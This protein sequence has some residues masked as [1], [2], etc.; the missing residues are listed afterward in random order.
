[1]NK[2]VNIFIIFAVLASVICS[3]YGVAYAELSGKWVYVSNYTNPDGSTGTGVS[4]V[5]VFQNGTE[6]VADNVATTWYNRQGR[7]YGKIIDTNPGTD[8]LAHTRRLIQFTRVDIDGGNYVG[9]RIGFVSEGDD[10][11]T[12]YFI[13][14]NGVEGTFVMTKQ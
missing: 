12:G 10:K 3:Q 11:I 1:M 9:V 2:K 14:V 7:L 5:T 4:E 6:F 13:D 8:T